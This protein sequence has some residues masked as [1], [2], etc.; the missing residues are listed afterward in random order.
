VDVLGA[1]VLLAATSPLLVAAAA[2]VALTMGRPVLFRQDRAGLHGRPFALLK[3]RSMHDVGTG[4]VSDAERL[5]PFG[6]ALRATSVDELPGLVNVLRGELSLV[7]PRPLPVRYLGRYSAE[8][9]RRHEVRPGVTGLAQVRGRNAVDWTER[10]ALD[11]EYV[12]RRSTALDLGILLSTVGVVLR[13]T[14]T[15]RPGEATMTEFRPETAAPR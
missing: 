3:L 5:T 10:L 13:R 12:D 4:R 7:G 6:R 9:A 2:G 8:Q 15:S 1:S 14:G 11:V